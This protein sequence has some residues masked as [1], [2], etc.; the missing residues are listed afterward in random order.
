MPLRIGEKFINLGST[1]NY[2]FERPDMRQRVR[3]TSAL[4][5]CAPAAR[6]RAHR[7]AAQRER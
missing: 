1:S 4:G 6:S 2:A 5:Y 3:A 7:A